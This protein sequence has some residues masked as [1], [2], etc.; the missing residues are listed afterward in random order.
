MAAGLKNV[1]IFHRPG[2]SIG[3]CMNFASALARFQYITKMDDDEFYAPYYLH[4]LI[5][6]FRRSKA[7][8]VGKRAMFIHLAG[9]RML[10]QWYTS[11]NRYVPWVAGG[12]ITYKKSV[13]RKVKFT[14][15][16]FAEDVRFLRA[17]RRKGFVVYAGDRYNFC[18]L[19]RKNYRSHTW[20]L[21]DQQFIRHPQ[22]KIIARQC[23]NYK[24]YVVR[25]LKKH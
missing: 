19:R 6:A 7:D 15:R 9:S 22:A 4:G 11:E 17:C 2:Q 20:Q 24:R 25:P 12:T 21:S 18:A 14:D 1:R 8:I 10:I 5:H 13:W 3:S 23:D 16:S